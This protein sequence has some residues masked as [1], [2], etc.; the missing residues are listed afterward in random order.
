MYIVIHKADA[1]LVSGP[2]S[3]LFTITLL[4]YILRKT[5]F[6]F[7]RSTYRYDSRLDNTETTA[8]IASGEMYPE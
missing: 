1:N 6:V 8:T 3:Y 5:T 2:I 7:A 4:Q